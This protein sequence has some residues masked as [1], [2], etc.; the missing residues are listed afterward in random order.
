MVYTITVC[1][2]VTDFPRFFLTTVSSLQLS[3]T[4][5]ET[6]RVGPLLVSFCINGLSFIISN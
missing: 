5:I 1:R 2:V 3:A 4:V 6:T